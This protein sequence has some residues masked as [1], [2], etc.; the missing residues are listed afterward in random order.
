MKEVAVAAGVSKATVSKVLSGKGSAL[1][2]SPTT[3]SH[4]RS[5]AAQLGYVLGPIIRYRPAEIDDR[6]QDQ[7]LE[8]T[9]TPTPPMTPPVDPVVVTPPPSGPPPPASTPVL[10]P[11]RPSGRRSRE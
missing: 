2:I 6:P 1:R 9:P 11:T 5:V 4:V 7:N 3:Q 8:P 10:R